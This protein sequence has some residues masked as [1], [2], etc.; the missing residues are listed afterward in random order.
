MIGGVR[1]ASREP[2]LRTVW[3]DLDLI[4][5]SLEGA[6]SI[7]KN[8]TMWRQMIDSAT[9]H[10]AMTPMQELAAKEEVKKIP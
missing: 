6:I 1:Q 8:R 10:R 4:V 9:H 2:W 5:T 3:T 7:A